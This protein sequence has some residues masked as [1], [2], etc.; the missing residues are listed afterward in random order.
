[1]SCA[2]GH[3][4]LLELAGLA[5]GVYVFGGVLRFGLLFQQLLRFRF[6]PVRYEPVAHGDV[7]PHL[8]A[9]Y[10]PSLSELAGLG[11]VEQG[12]CR[13]W[14]LVGY[15][16]PSATFAAV[17]HHPASGAWA[18]V[19]LAVAPD[20]WLPVS[21]TFVSLFQDDALTLTVNGLRHTLLDAEA[22]TDT[23]LVDPYAASVPEQW[24][25]HREAMAEGGQVQD[26]AETSTLLA[27]LQ[28][29]A[30]LYLEN[31]KQR[32]RLRPS[33]GS[34]LEITLRAGAE[35]AIESARGTKR[36]RA[37]LA[38]R[39]RAGH[40]PVS[41]PLVEEVALFERLESLRRQ[42]GRRE[43]QLGLFG[44]TALLFGGSMGLLF[45]PL[46]VLLLSAVVLFHELGHYAAMRAFGIGD[47]TI[48]FLP[49]LG[50][51]TVGRR[52][53]APVGQELVILLA[54]PVPGLLLAGLAAGIS[55]P[56][57]GSWQQQA[58]LMLVVVN[59]FNLLPIFPLDGGRVLHAL[60]FRRQRW[61][62]A[63]FLLAAGLTLFAIGLRFD[64]RLLALLGIVVGAT[65][66][67]RLRVGWLLG[68]LRKGPALPGES[69]AQRV[70]RV[71]NTHGYQASS[72]GRK[73]SMARGL[74]QRSAE[75]RAGIATTL[76][77]LVGYLGALGG[78]LVLLVEV[79]LPPL[80]PERDVAARRAAVAAAPAEA[81]T[82]RCG[83][84]LPPLGAA[85]G[86]FGLA[87]YLDAELPTVP[88]AR[89]LEGSLASFFAAAPRFPGLRP[90]WRATALPLERLREQ[91]RARSTYRR[92]QEV[93]RRSS[94]GR[95]V[96]ARGF[97]RRLAGCDDGLHERSA[98]RGENEPAKGL[99]DVGR[100]EGGDE[101]SGADLRRL[102]EWRAEAV[103]RYVE[104]DKQGV[105]DRLTVA[106]YR[107]L[108]AARDRAAERDAL[109]SLA[110]RLGLDES[111]SANEPSPRGGPTALGQVQRA[112]RR[113]VLPYL[114]LPH[115]E[116]LAELTHYLCQVGVDELRI[117]PLAAGQ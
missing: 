63:A 3:V 83:A 11:F 6:H 26:P 53:G 97:Y 29:S 76:V 113:I 67:H 58:L 8:L 89:A 16:E 86:R 78:S 81:T 102:R 50:A 33:A 27:R 69:A 111:A 80:S 2:P 49:F 28:A 107:E 18:L 115:A 13:E 84:A 112:G 92:L 51:A 19:S 87:V 117:A 110:E 90:P 34:G 1:M 99:T 25:A 43:V 77:G 20:R 35:L 88:R 104:R 94:S 48:F 5:L 9:L 108:L 65:V 32:G 45:D 47:A 68:S 4:G 79:A 74:L 72:V 46:T 95:T 71:L 15:P 31:L 55:A 36:M 61:L 24:R 96:D 114:W 56:S 64:S 109:R 7:P 38:R 41:L 12:Y 22:M 54:G 106:R 10:R 39:A 30:D 82:Y 91:E 59:L 23:R 17:L 85:R 101:A 105:L 66:P 100:K 37:M 62:E 73:V 93:A 60:I 98:R 42:P 52:D 40:P 21:V 57:I 14:R 70:F 44:L 116:A 75:R 103:R